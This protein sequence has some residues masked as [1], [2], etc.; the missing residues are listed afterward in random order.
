M[1]ARYQPKFHSIDVLC[2]RNRACLAG[3]SGCADEEVLVRLVRGLEDARLHAIHR[4][5][6][7]EGGLP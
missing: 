7:R 1:S 4:L 3:T 2:L 6:F 5:V